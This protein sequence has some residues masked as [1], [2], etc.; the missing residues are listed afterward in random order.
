VDSRNQVRRLPPSAHEIKF[1]GYRRQLNRAGQAI[2]LLTR[3]GYDWTRKFPGLAKVAE[4]LPDC[5][6][7][8]ELTAVD[9]R[10]APVFSDLQS[11][12]ASGSTGSLVYFAFDLLSLDGADLRKLPLLERKQRLQRLI[13]KLPAKQTCIHYVDHFTGDSATFLRHV[14]ALG[15]EGLVSKSVDARYVSGRTK[16][17]VKVKCLAEYEVVIGGWIERGGRLAAFL[18]GET[19]LRYLGRLG[20]TISE[21][22]ARDLLALLRTLEIPTSPFLHEAGTARAG[23]KRL[24]PRSKAVRWAK[25]RLK[26]VISYLT[27]TKSGRL[28][29]HSIKKIVEIEEKRRR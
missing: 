9:E 14:C 8:G 18:I 4:S 24:G 10:G 27:R 2:K 22:H 6:I 17:W 26:A 12:I 3:N 1:D 16:S 25:P 5:V 28:R 13:K 20:A 19:D 23:S 15:L 7:D 29:H 11:A 21:K